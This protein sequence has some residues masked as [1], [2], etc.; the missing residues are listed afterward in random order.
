MTDRF[1]QFVLDQARY[2]L[3]DS[4]ALTI[5]EDHQRWLS[6]LQALQQQVRDWLVEYERDGNVEVQTED[7][8]IQ[9]ELT[10]SYKVSLMK[11]RIGSLVVKLK[12]IGSF[13]I[14]AYGRVDMEGPRGVSKLVLVQK[15]SK[16]PK[17]TVNFYSGESSP[18][19]A[20]GPVKQPVLAWK[21][22]TPPP[23]V[24]YIDL[25][26]EVFLDEMM[27]VAEGG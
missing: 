19:T 4:G 8:I 11:I 6:N 2:A 20:P 10:G 12:P 1:K 13:L 7:I 16:E 26:K 18:S 21:I 3:V 14:A 25:T 23:S 27:R 17:I 9:E 24:K 5:E 15:D 22:A